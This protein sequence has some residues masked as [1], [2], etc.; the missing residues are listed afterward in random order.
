MFFHFN[1]QGKSQLSGVIVSND[2]E[3]L[4]FTKE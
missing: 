1:W 4:I 3:Y 2:S